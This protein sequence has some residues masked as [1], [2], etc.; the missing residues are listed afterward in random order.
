MRQFCEYTHKTQTEKHIQIPLKPL[1]SLLVVFVYVE[2]ETT[3]S[4]EGIF[5]Q[6]N[7]IKDVAFLS[8]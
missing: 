5:E 8:V 6:F 7:K 1:P 2:T 3:S 4:S